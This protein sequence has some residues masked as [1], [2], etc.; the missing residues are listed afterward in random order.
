[1]KRFL[2]GCVGATLFFTLLGAKENLKKEFE[3]GAAPELVV[4]ADVALIE[5]KPGSEGKIVAHVEL[6]QKNRYRLSSS[7]DGDLVSITLE[8]KGLRGWLFAPVDVILDETSKITLEVPEGTKLALS[9]D[10]GNIEVAEIEASLRAR[11]DAGTIRISDFKGEADINSGSG[12]VRIEKFSGSL[13]AGTQAGVVDIED[14]QGAFSV[15]TGVGSVDIDR[16]SGGFKVRSEVGTVDFEGSITRGED[17][18]FRSGV[19]SVNITLYETTNLEIDAES[20][21]DS[22]SITPEPRSTTRGDHYLKATIGSGEAK[23]SIC[24]DVGSISIRKG[25]EWEEVSGEEEAH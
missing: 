16:S 23:V 18:Y 6:A 20:D 21:L 7:Q 1:M 9:N 24:T 8:R 11:T 13:D 2:V 3:V 25:E 4:D 19:G 22:V 15:N 12:A 10:A 14:S 17:N 5:V